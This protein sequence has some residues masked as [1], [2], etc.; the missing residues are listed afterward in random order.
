M[1]IVYILTETE[2]RENYRFFDLT[3]GGVDSK[4]G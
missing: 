3:C 4:A 1:I 2:I